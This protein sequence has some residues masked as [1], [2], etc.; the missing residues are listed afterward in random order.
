MS[1]EQL[2]DQYPDE[3]PGLLRE[4]L[5]WAKTTRELEGGKGSVFLVS[6]PSKNARLGY[7]ARV[8]VLA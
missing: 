7:G 8:S 6:I 2:Q 1:L 4:A 3:D 5:H